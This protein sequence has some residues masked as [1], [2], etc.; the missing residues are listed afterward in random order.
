M[1]INEL[2]RISLSKH[3]I[4]GLGGFK[5]E[6]LINF[7]NSAANIVIGVNGSGKSTILNSIASIINSMVIQFNRGG[8]GNYG[9]DMESVSLNSINSI[10]RSD[11]FIEKEGLPSQSYK[12]YNAFPLDKNH[13]VEVQRNDNSKVQKIFLDIYQSKSEEKLLPVFR[14]FQCVKNVMGGKVA[15]LRFNQMHNRNLGYENMFGEVIKLDEIT[16]LMVNQINIENQY[17]IEKEDLKAETVIGK[18]IRN[19]LNVFTTMLYSEKTLVSVGK[20]NYSTVQSLRLLKGDDYFEF[21]QLSSG[22]KYVFS[23]VLDLIYR[24]VSLNFNS[25][26]LNE[27]AGIVLIDEIESHLHPKW[28]LTIIKALEKTFPNIQFIVSTHSPLI[29][30]S[31]RKDQIIA[32]NNFEIISSKDLPDVYS[33]SSN[34]ILEK[35]LHTESKINLYDPEKKEIDRLINNMKF[36]EAEEKLIELKKRVDSSPQWLKDLEQLINFGKL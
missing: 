17:K 30:S 10:I 14:Y 8:S 13:S 7:N 12:I 18:Y 19:C 23:V 5:Y 4:E 11:V 2:K 15:S 20:S 1:N 24:N 32:I 36:K 26:K 29:A 21:S 34:E 25:D 6:T 27:T 31:V 9:I 33:G 28:Q 22:E 16:S 3:S 35:I